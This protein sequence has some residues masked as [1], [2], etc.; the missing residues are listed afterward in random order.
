MRVDAASTYGQHLSEHDSRV[1]RLDV[2]L[3]R[4]LRHPLPDECGEKGYSTATA[5]R[6]PART[7]GTKR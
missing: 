2:L 3:G 7:P 6:N 5:Y 4:A 1:W